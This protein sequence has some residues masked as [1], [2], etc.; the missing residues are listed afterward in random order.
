MKSRIRILTKRAAIIESVRTLERGF[1]GSAT[2]SASTLASSSFKEAGFDIVAM[3]GSISSIA[4]TVS[5]TSRL[6]RLG[7]IE[8]VYCEDV[9]ENNSLITIDGERRTLCPQWVGALFC[10]LFWR[11]TDKCGGRGEVSEI[12]TFK[13]RSPTTHLTAAQQEFR[14]H[15]RLREIRIWLVREAE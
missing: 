8:A 6:F 15:Q 1:A 2:S 4:S 11:H 3:G 13:G 12:M 7:I 14:Y 10:C 9:Y 5:L